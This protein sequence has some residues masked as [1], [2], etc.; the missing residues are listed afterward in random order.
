MHPAIREKR[1]RG[2]PALSP[3]AG[4][5]ARESAGDAAEASAAGGL[6]RPGAVRAGARCPRQRP[7]PGR[8]RPEQPAGPHR[9]AAK[10]HRDHRLHGTARDAFAAHRRLRARA[11]PVAAGGRCRSA[12]HPRGP[13][14]MR[15]RQRPR[16]SKGCTARAN[17]SLKALQLA[18]AAQAQAQARMRQAQTEFLLRWAP[19]ARL[20][21]AQRARL[22]EDLAAGRQL[23]LRA[24]LPGRHSLGTT[25]HRGTG[26]CRRC[27][28]AGARPRRAV[29]NRGRDAERR[30][31]AADDPSSG[32]PRPGRAA[33]GHA[34]K[35]GIGTDAWSRMGP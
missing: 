6:R 10:R 15:L 35:A 27:R 4:K 18:Q 1:C 11:R 34:S 20:D 32:R 8:S 29:G 19:L 28:G 23:L 14:P 2:Q 5:W 3:A 24:D 13:P 33:A 17:M 22:I 21:G 31:A 9:R 7:G 12:R 30:S 26:R 25:A 16:G